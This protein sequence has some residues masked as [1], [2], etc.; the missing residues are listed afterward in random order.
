M[1]DRA[2]ESKALQFTDVV[3]FRVHGLLAIGKRV[4]LFAGFDLLPKQPS[5]T[6]ELVWQGALLGARVGFDSKFSAYAR[7]QGGP[8]LGRDGY[9]VMGEAAMQAKLELAEK[10]LFWD[11]TVGATYTQLFPDEPVTRRFWQTELLAETGLA[12]REKRGFFATWLT[13][14]FHFPLVAR[15]LTSNP[16][17]DRGALD[18]Q[19]RVGVSLGVLAGVTRSLDFFIEVSTLDRGDLENAQTTLPIL[20]GGFD[21]RR[22]LFGFN[23]RFGTRKR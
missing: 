10:A 3:L 9:W 12:I 18:P 21:Q 14:S 17:G 2:P 13:F 4:E 7:T 23:R 1:R 8:G 16:D 22:L 6:D 20:S 19:T 5:Y 11:S 15:P